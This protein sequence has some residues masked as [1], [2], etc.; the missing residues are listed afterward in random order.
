MDRDTVLRCLAGTLDADVQVRKQSESQLK[1]F[2]QQPGFTVSLLDLINDANTNT[3]IKMSAAIFFKNR[4]V[5]YWTVPEN[6]AG[7]PMYIQN[8][9]KDAIKQKLIETIISCYKNHQLG[10]QLSTSLHNILSFD[11]WD[12]LVE[13]IK[14]LLSDTSNVDH[15]HT[16]LICL[17]EYTKNYRWSGLESD[18]SANP[19]LEE[20]TS[21]IFPMLSSLAS[22]LLANDNEFSDQMLYLII[23]TFKFATFSALPTYLQDP[24]NLGH[25]CHLHIMIINKPLPGAVL[26][27]DSI[28]LRNSHPRVKTVKWC[29]GNLHR[30]LSRHGGGFATKD[31]PDS[32]FVKYFLE[33]F[34][35]EILNSYWKI[36][37]NWST[38]SIWLSESSLYHLI[39]FLEQLVQTPAWSLISDKLDAIIRHVILPTLNATDETIELYEDDSDEYVRRFFDIN[40]ESNTS[41]VASINFIFRLS[42]K[43]FKSTINLILTIINDI[44]NRR[45]ANRGDIQVA[46]EV[47]GAFRVLSTI[48]YKLSSKLSPVANQV[49]K[50]LHTFVY[51][52]LSSETIASTPWLTARACDTLAMFNNKYQDQQILRDVFEGIIRCFQTQEQFPIQITAVDALCTL[53]EDDSVADH[54]SDQAPQLMGTL[55]EMSKKF[56]SDILTTVMETFVEKFAKNLEPYATELASKLVELFLRLATEILKQQTGENGEFDTE[57]EYQ[58]AGHLNTLGTLVIAMSHSP[59]VARSLEPV[60]ED[61]VKFVLENAQI[62]FITEIIEILESILFSTKSVSPT[63]WNL[64]VVSINAFDTYA[65]EYFDSFLP[66]FERIINCGFTNPEV[67]LDSPYVQSLINVCNGILKKEDID[68]LFADSA[69]EILELIILAMGDRFV[70]ILPAFLSEIYQIFSTLE[71]Q[72]AFDGYMLHHLSILKVLFS[73]LYVDA[74]TTMKFL[75]E[76][77]FVASFFKLWMKHSED[78][79]SVYGCKLQI[80]ASLSIIN[81]DAITYIPEDLVGETVDL[82]FSNIAALPTAIKA[83]DEILEKEAGF[84]HNPSEVAEG[85]DEDEDEYAGAYYE[86]DLEADE[87]ELDALKQTPIDDLNV[88]S[89]AARQFVNLQQNQEKFQHLFGDIA[90]E[91]QKLISDLIEITSNEH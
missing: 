51:P 21:E 35:P 22:E 41:D 10:L 38:K 2:E 67:T 28:E 20:I 11:K 30:L 7:G 86:D 5:N 82:L 39:S 14:K 8:D 44:F 63:M 90:Q 46:K 69:F 87:A 1:I 77:Q 50:L 78:F 80:L 49:D 60:V 6:K 37:E 32:P 64:Y 9:E 4:I 23:K 40:R 12:Q 24:A 31:K 74:V 15:V 42:S 45:N 66:F 76:Q 13:I 56:E 52:E 34:V 57:K 33:N 43:R 73:A 29:F 83:R 3:G 19:V 65:F 71:S 79:Q 62:A 27:E 61:M 72:N 48:S 18:S 70:G 58:A 75:N 85:D 36:I 53:V 89:I 55:L 88:F 47:E 81:S 16:G 26:N 59:T 84:K 17:Y 25:W 91:K 68:P 54:I